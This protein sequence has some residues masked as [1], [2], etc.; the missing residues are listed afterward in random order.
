MPAAS[1]LVPHYRQSNPGACLPA[2]ARM[3]LAALGEERT[4]AQLATVL[5]VSTRW[6]QIALDVFLEQTYSLNDQ[7]VLL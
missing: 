3:V 2:C 5:T 6:R 4:E 1:T 7:E